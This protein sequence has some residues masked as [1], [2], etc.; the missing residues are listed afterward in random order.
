MRDNTLM[1]VEIRERAFDPWTEVAH[2]QASLT[3]FGA[4]AVFVGTMRDINE[5]SKVDR[6][7]IEHYPGMTEIHLNNI[8]KRAGARWNIIDALVIHRVGE[9]YPNDTIVLV[10]VWSAH[11]KDAY[12]ANRFIMEDL[13]SSAP[14]WKKETLDGGE[15]WVGKNTPGY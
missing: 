4:T 12:E 6:M 5:S 15:R 11:R 1:K 10:A 2:Y 7:M 8:C 14:F 9:L 3:S 13:K